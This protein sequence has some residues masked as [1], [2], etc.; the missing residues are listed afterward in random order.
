MF[1][2]CRSG[3]DNHFNQ[4]CLRVGNFLD[5]NKKTLPSIIA[6]LPLSVTR[7]AREKEKLANI[8]AYGEDQP[9]IPMKNIRVRLEP[10]S[11]LPDRFDER[12]Y[13]SEL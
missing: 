9:K 6:F 4:L 3:Q 7:S 11:P 12:E 8:M 13:G 2:T 10:L 1:L 5:R